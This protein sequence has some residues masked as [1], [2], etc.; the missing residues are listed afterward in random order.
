MA[1][2]TLTIDARSIQG[3]PADV[4]IVVDL[5]GADWLRPGAI[6]GQGGAYVANLP[7]TVHT[8]QQGRAQVQL[9]ATADFVNSTGYTLRIGSARPISF[10]M[11]DSDSNFYALTQTP[12]PPPTPAALP[13]GLTEGDVVIGQDGE[14][15][16]KKILHLAPTPPS[17]PAT[18]AIWWDSTTTP[19]DPRY[20]TNAGQSWNEFRDPA[21]MAAALNS[22]TGV[23]R[24]DGAH[25]QGQVVAPVIIGTAPPATT[26]YRPGS[27]VIVQA[28]GQ[29]ATGTF[30]FLTQDTQVA[31]GNQNRLQ[32]VIANNVIQQTPPAADNYQNILGS[33]HIRTVGQDTVITI[34]LDTGVG[35]EPPPDQIWIRG[36]EPANA[37]SEF[38]GGLGT[39]LHILGGVADTSNST[40]LCPPRSPPPASGG[41][42][43]GCCSPM[44]P[45]PKRT[46]SNRLLSLSPA[47]GWK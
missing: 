17:N 25:I 3:D 4:S 18:T 15:Q 21:D 24:L 46:I 31:V 1:I 42:R 41:R 16:L 27:S 28:S 13:V 6:P 10:V 11:P 32:F 36:L 37:L 47:S 12:A 43:P 45:E 19:P 8:D 35:T 34:R 2:R 20:T 44:W 7:V 30:Y 40:M 9:A 26:G 23:D 14:Y 33:I 5:A 29:T 22:L 38:R 39:A